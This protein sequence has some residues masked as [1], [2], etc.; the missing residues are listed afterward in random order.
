MKRVKL[1]LLVIS[2][3]ISSKLTSQVAVNTDG[4]KASGSAILDIKSDTK[5]FLIPRMS[6]AQIAA[7]I[8]PADGLQV[9]NSDDGKL[10]GFVRADNEWKEIAY[11]TANIIPPYFMPIPFLDDFESE[12]DTDFEFW[13]AENIE[14]WHYWHVIAWGGNNGAHCMRFENTDIIQDDWLITKAVVCEGADQIQISFNHFFFGNRLNKPTLLYTS[15]YNGNAAQSVWTELDYSLGENE[16]EWYS[17]GNIILQNP[18]DVLYFA[19]HYQSDAENS[20]YFLLD[21]FS[22]SE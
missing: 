8:N 4:S 21:N 18:G 16:N 7:I 17:T 3:I 10:Y 22:I 12:N 11:G 5:G 1:L 15:Q 2:I 9:Y 20:I 14:G 19:F 13:T 6:Q